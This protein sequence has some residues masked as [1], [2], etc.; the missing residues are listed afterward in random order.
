MVPKKK[1][2]PKKGAPTL[3]KTVPLLDSRKGDLTTKTPPL[4]PKAALGDDVGKSS[5]T[6][7]SAPKL[8]TKLSGGSVPKKDGKG[9]IPLAPKKKIPAGRPSAE[10]SSGI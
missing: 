8:V 3:K 1:L 9:I 2:P 4:V 10:S 6:K 7:G 5:T